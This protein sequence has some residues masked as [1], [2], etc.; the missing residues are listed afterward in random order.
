VT[1]A[2]IITH[3]DVDGMVCAAQ[4]IRREGTGNELH[5]SNARWVASKLRALGKRSAPPQKVYVA[6][7]AANADALSAVRQLADTGVSVYWIDHHPWPRGLPDR[8]SQVCEHLIYRNSLR[9]PAGTLLGQWLQDEEPYCGR[10]GRICYAFEKGTSWERNWFRLLSS[11]V[12]KCG[13]DVLERLAF[14]RDLTDD[15]LARI[16]GQV[17]L[18]KQAEA[19]LAERPDTVTTTHGRTM[20]VYDTSNTPG[21]YLGRKVFEW[22]PVDYCLIR[23]RSRKWQIASNPRDSLA[24]DALVGRH[25]LAGLAIRAG[26]RPSRLLA[27]ESASD[28][29]ISDAHD[30]VIAW[31]RDLL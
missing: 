9:R 5:F 8:M 19:V 14:D 22:H 21:V 31:A 7:I 16:E 1:N 20:A 2:A 15:D 13:T 3:G 12:G 6:D 24:L 4:L 18:E 27:I 11:Y 30:R 28:T 25:D 23:I 10:V 17:A 29:I 26:G